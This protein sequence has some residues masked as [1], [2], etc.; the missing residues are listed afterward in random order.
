MPCPWRSSRQG[1]MGLWAT[2]S[3]TWSDSWQ[4]YLQQRDWN[5]KILEVSSNPRILCFCISMKW[6][7][8]NALLA[9][10]SCHEIS[11]QSHHSFTTWIPASFLNLALFPSPVHW[12]HRSR[13]IILALCSFRLAVLSWD[14]P[15]LKSSTDHLSLAFFVLI[16]IMMSE[17]GNEEWMEFGTTDK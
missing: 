3:S 11:V 8:S 15:S 16:C 9:D 1:W 13:V 6:F 12:Q 7:I 17:V 5:V 4:P 14:L 10:R 2:W